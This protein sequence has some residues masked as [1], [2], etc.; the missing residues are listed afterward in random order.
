MAEP[1]AVVIGTLDAGVIFS[2]GGSGYGLIDPEEIRSRV[3][4]VLSPSDYASNQARG[5][6]MTYS[7]AVAFVR[8]ALADL[9]STTD[10]R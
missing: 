9:A 7:D 8:A 1:A 2:F 4:G 10:A 3:V 6:A 5:A